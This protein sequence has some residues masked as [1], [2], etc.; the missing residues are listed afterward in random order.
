MRH[1]ESLEHLE[2][3]SKRSRQQLDRLNTLAEKTQRTRSDLKRFELEKKAVDELN[4]VDELNSKT[5]LLLNRYTE[6]SQDFESRSKESV[7]KAKN[8]ADWFTKTLQATNSAKANLN[9]V[10]FIKKC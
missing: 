10:S 9:M 7:E 6:S 1:K 3:Q 2:N 4:Q 8:A 5:N